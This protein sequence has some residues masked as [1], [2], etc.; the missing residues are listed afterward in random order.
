MSDPASK[1]A[2]NGRRFDR[3][4]LGH[5]QEVVMTVEEWRAFLNTS[6][7]PKEDLEIY[8]KMLPPGIS[9]GSK[10]LLRK[11][12][13][14]RGAVVKRAPG[15]GLLRFLQMFCSKS[16]RELVLEALVAEYL[17]E[18][19]EALNRKEYFHAR[20]IAVKLH[21]WLLYSVFGGVA[22]WVVDKALGVAISK[23]RG[24]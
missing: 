16:F 21:F 5:F 14:N 7:I 24:D 11:R 22:G 17:S 20:W 8:R 3:E 2:K 6:G 19:Y 23:M 10:I 12:I 18:Y 9:V 13:R 4:T 15:Y 1:K